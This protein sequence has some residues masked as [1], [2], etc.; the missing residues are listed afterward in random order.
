MDRQMANT[1]K[2]NPIRGISRVARIVPWVAHRPV[3]VWTS[4]AMI[5]LL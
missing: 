5:F 1:M 4:L 3:W 2:G